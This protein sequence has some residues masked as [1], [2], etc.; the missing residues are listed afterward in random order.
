MLMARRS[1]TSFLLVLYFFFLRK[2]L[3]SLT[4]FLAGVDVPIN[5]LGNPYTFS[6]FLMLAIMSFSSLLH[7]SAKSANA[8]SWL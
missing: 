5:L 2:V 7:F 4:L 8:T 1:S 3:N 6:C